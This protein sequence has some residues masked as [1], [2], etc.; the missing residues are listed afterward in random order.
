MSR[1]AN[2][3]GLR[4]VVTKYK[5]L[6]LKEESL[7]KQVEAAEASLRI[8]KESYKNSKE[9]NAK[10]RQAIRL[11]YYI[12][13]RGIDRLLD[14]EQSCFVSI[15]V[16][17][18]PLLTEQIEVLDLY[19]DIVD[20]L[21]NMRLHYVGELVQKTSKELKELNSQHR[22]FYSSRFPDDFIL[23]IKKAL[24]EK[25]LHLGIEVTDWVKLPKPEKTTSGTTQ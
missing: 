24:Q 23:R 25:S 22:N 10:A 20:Q 5:K 8:I 17:D 13:E 12:E 2:Q 4:Q 19:S 3:A 16:G 18:H 1:K 15:T 14:S 11:L 9:E 7:L 21:Q 6:L